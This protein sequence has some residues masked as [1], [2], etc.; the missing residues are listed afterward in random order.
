M[1]AWVTASQLIGDSASP[2]HKAGPCA[3]RQLQPVIAMLLA[4]QW[5]CVCCTLMLCHLQVQ[6]ESA[7]MVVALLDPQAGERVLDACAAP[8]GKALFA[9]AR[10]Q[11]RVSP[12]T[13]MTVDCWTHL[14]EQ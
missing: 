11:G 5:Q 3:V 8:G 2:A 12:C 1:H 9:A 13:V 6:D 7:G 4:A 10:M 14:A